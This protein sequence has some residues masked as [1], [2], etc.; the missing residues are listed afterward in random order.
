MDDTSTFGS[1]PHYSAGPETPAGSD[2]M[3]GRHRSLTALRNL[4]ATWHRRS[5]FRRALEQKS[6]DN[7]HLIDDIGL[8]RRQV[9]AEIAKP[10]WQQ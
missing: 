1:A 5:R 3:P 8:T 2:D 4:I 9:E 10:F 6:K 7:P